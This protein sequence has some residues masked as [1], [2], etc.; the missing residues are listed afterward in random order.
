MTTPIA[1]LFNPGDSVYVIDTTP[2]SSCSNSPSCCGGAHWQSQ[3]SIPL[4]GP[5]SYQ[6]VYAIR[7]GQV[8]SLNANQLVVDTTPTVS[9]NVRFNTGPGSKVFTETMFQGNTPIPIMFTGDTP[10]LTAALTQYGMLV[11]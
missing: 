8:L 5:G 9:Y 6:G 7:K 11:A 4:V 10:G 2:C 1:H 3:A